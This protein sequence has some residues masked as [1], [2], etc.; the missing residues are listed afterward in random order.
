MTRSS[1]WD[2]L[3]TIEDF[4]IHAL[5]KIRNL[6]SVPWLFGYGVFKAT[7][8]SWETMCCKLFMIK[9]MRKEIAAGGG[10]GGGGGGEKR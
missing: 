4:I 7:S 9:D 10:E 2:C 1:D 6:T 3:Q 5:E 8:P